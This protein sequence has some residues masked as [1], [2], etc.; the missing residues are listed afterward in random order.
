[1]GT[2]TKKK[3]PAKSNKAAM[4]AVSKKPRIV[5]VSI[6]LDDDVADAYEQAVR[7]LHAK[8][9]ELLASRARRVAAAR[10]ATR[11][12]DDQ[13]DALN[14]VVMEDEKV[15]EGLRQAVDAA[16]EALEAET[17]VF[18]FRA[19]GRAAWEALKAAHPAHEDDHEAV[20]EATGKDDARAEYHADSLAPALIAAA[21][22]SP[23]LTEEYVQEHII[24]GDAWNDTEITTLFQ[25]A[26][27]AQISARENPLGK[28]HA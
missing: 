14:L 24:N 13:A 18:K 23:R 7:A 19:L 10:S 5:S 22:V 17:Q 3:A 27:I 25:H 20:R 26:L 6:V 16:R 12:L 15:L 8:E 1:M 4:D 21:C 2:S 28:A 11:D 9:Q